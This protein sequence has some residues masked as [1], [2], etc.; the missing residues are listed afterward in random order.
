M[1][2]NTLA[3]APCSPGKPAPRVCII[4]TAHEARD[5]R[6][7]HKQA[8]SLARA[9]FDVS[10]I[11]NWSADMESGPVRKLALPAL[12]GKLSRWVQGSFGA[13]RLALKERAAVYHFH[14][15]ELLPLGVALKLCGKRVICDVHEDYSKKILSRGLPP[16][17]GALASKCL[18]AFE[19]VCARSFDHVVTADSHVA[20]L[21][22]SARTTVIANYPPLQFVQIT[23]GDRARDPRAEFRIAYVGG[24]NRIRGIGKIIE[25]LDLVG[26]P[27]VVFHLAGNVAEKELLRTIERHPRV[28][29]HGVLPWEQV[30]RLLAQAD[31]GMVLFQPVPAFEYY[32]GENIIKL[33][34]YLGLGL[35]VIISNFPKLK[36]LIETLDAGIAVDPA[37]PAAIAAAI[38]QL[39]D[40]PEL[41]RRL[42]QNGRA[43]VRNERNWE[44]EAGKL[45]GIYRR[46]LQTADA[47]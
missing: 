6:I 28:V 4:T 26:D 14:D 32:P 27:P 31:V 22:S 44:Q 47:A 15:P 2:P 40:D 3:D 25:A 30:N 37:N 33:W 34:E 43:A 12:R 21:F 29:Y 11:A 46:M 19:A 5:D 36:R 38:R 7:Y 1:A 39:R 8:L 10:M 42:S 13:F 18:R 23:A 9:G 24:I 35:P 17:A 45:I 16:M 41:R 20:S